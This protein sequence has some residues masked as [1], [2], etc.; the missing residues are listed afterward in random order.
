MIDE[1]LNYERA[2]IFLQKKI[3]AHVVKTNKVFYNGLIV[4]VDLTCF[5]IE[6]IED[7]RQLILFKQLNKDIEEYHPEKKN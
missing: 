4:E 3:P 5:F 2:L 1:Q 7:G 6:D